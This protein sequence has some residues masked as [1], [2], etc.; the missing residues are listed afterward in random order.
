MHVVSF[1]AV[2][3]IGVWSNFNIVLSKTVCTRKFFCYFSFPW[4][5]EFLIFTLIHLFFHSC[6]CLFYPKYSVPK[7]LVPPFLV[8]FPRQKPLSTS[9]LTAITT[10]LVISAPDLRRLLRTDLISVS[11]ASD[12]NRGLPSKNYLQIKEL[13]TSRKSIQSAN[14]RTI[15]ISKNYLQVE[16]MSAFSAGQSLICR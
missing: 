9:F 14:Q 11:I 7:V 8:I 4:K 2:D 12:T 6:S 1:W 15:C 5:C 16:E 13:S 3:P 10:F